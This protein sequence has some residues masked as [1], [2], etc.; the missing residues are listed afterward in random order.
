MVAP[1]GIATL[2]GPEREQEVKEKI[3][4]GLETYRTEDG[5]Y[6]LRNEFHFLVARA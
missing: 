4:E 1:A 3:V 5:G 2:V 6:R